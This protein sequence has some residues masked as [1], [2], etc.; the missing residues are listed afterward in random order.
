MKRLFLLI[1][2]LSVAMG[3]YA[4]EIKGKVYHKKSGIAGVVVTDGKQFT[5]TDTEGNYTLNVGEDTKYVYI[6]TPSGY[7]TSCDTGSPNFYRCTDGKNFDFELFK[8]GVPGGKYVLFA[9]GDPQPRGENAFYR[10]E[11]EAFA[12]LKSEGEKYIN[13]HIPVISLFLGDI[14]YD[15]LEFFPRMKNMMKEI[16]YPIYPVIG[17]H[18][19][20]ANVAD[21]E[22]SAHIYN[23]YF[24]PANYAF[25][26]GKDYFI[27]LDNIIYNGNKSY[28]EGV[29]DEQIEW[30]KNYLKFVPKGSHIFL[31]MH[32]QIYYYRA[33]SYE[34]LKA[35]ELLDAFDDY[36]LTLLTGHSHIQGNTTHRKNVQEYNVASIGG[37]WWLWDSKYSR[38]GTPIGYQVFESD[39]NG[40]KNH[41]KSIGYPA[42]YQM[43]VFPIG[44]VDGYADQLC[45]KIWNWDSRWRVEWYEDGKAKGEMPRVTMSDPDYSMYLQHQY[46]LDA[47][48]VNKGTQA[49]SDVYFYFAVKPSKGAK[50]I[51][52]VATDASGREYVEIVKL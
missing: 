12:E 19:H 35:K 37:A 24:G 31:A 14:L 51:Q 46:I 29:K 32:A 23:Y 6:V 44:T 16:G 20:D 7:M 30:V 5:Q 4:K 17:N 41:F 22:G 52:I 1:I 50:E 26:A 49:I 40:I 28:K 39:A 2:A 3:T 38:D 9:V 8:W 18:D 15:N 21:D 45:V 42:D 10:L 48:K 27:V 25:N 43:R 11:H 34:M 36:K 33:G 13:G 47:S